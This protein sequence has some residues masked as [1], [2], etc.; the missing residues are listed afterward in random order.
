MAVTKNNQSPPLINP[1][2]NPEIKE[3]GRLGYNGT[4]VWIGG[5]IILE[6]IFVAINIAFSVPIFS[7]LVQG[8]LSIMV[9]SIGLS[10][11][12]SGV[13]K[14]S[15]VY[16][17]PSIKKNF[18]ISSGMIILTLMVSTFFN[19]YE[20]INSYNYTNFGS[21]F[22]ATSSSTPEL[23]IIALV[24]GFILS[25]VSYLFMYNSYNKI[26]K[27]TG[28]NEFYTAGII[29]LI[30][31]FLSIIIIGDILIL[32]GAAYAGSTW[33]KLK[34]GEDVSSPKS[35]SKTTKS[36]L[37]MAMNQSNQTS[38]ISTSKQIITDAGRLGY[39][40]SL[41]WIL[42]SIIITVIFLAF[43][44]FLPYTLTQLYGPF[45]IIQ[46]AASFIILFIGL[47]FISKGVKNLSIFY[48]NNEIYRNFIISM[49][50]ILASLI[51]IPIIDYAI[52]NQAGLGSLFN[53]ASSNSTAYNI[54]STPSTLSF[55]NIFLI[56]I[57]LIAISLVILLLGYAFIY[58]SYK[59]ISK[60]T[61]ITEFNTG[62]L[63]MILGVVLSVV[64]IGNIVIL[65]GLIYAGLGWNKLKN[66]TAVN[67][68]IIPSKKKVKDNEMK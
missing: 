24:L 26:S 47:I 17:D 32:I 3:A 25:I 63:I 37:V 31:A 58:L 54:S 30:G 40:G 35:K 34:S 11:I 22:T 19:V 60:L 49:V 5:S 51:L 38:S 15:V 33:Y 44:F 12:T 4:A 42:G 29:L 59:K 62:A 41:I 43:D 55:S 13:Q 68:P 65:I 14:L 64:S 18:M 10:I 2:I 21:T 1:E 39:S 53:L 45:Y 66:G 16:K 7:L 46:I 6:V 28:K 61:G 57:L 9:T 56:P 23:Y 67:N 20:A 8:I 52:V 27:L 50:I 48:K 36:T